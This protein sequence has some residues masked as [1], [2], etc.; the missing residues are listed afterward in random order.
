MVSFRRARR[1]RA[2]SLFAV[3]ALLAVALGI[4]S[5]ATAS[6]CPG[7]QLTQ[8]DNVSSVVEQGGQGETFCL[9]AGVYHIS[10]PLKLRTG[11]T[12][13]GD[14]GAVIDGSRQVGGWSQSGSV[15]V[16]ANQIAKPLYSMAGWGDKGMMYPQSAYGDDLFYDGGALWKAGLK[17]GGKVLGEPASSVGPGEYFIDYDAATI[18]LGSNPAGHLVELAVAEDGVVGGGDRVTVR[19]LEIRKMAGTGIRSGGVGWTIAGN[20]VHHNHVVGI[21][22]NDGARVVTNSVHHNGQYGITGRGDGVL[23]EDNDVAFNDLAKFYGANGNCSAAGGSKFVNTTNLVVRNN[24]FHDNLCNGI[25][26]DILTAGALVEGNVSERNVADGFRTEISYNVTFRNNVAADNGRGGIIINNTPGATV[27]GNTVMGNAGAAISLG[28]SGRTD[29]VSPLGPHETRNADVHDN[30]VVLRRGDVTGM[31]SSVR[32]DCYAG[33]NNRFYRNQYV[34]P[35]LSERMF[36]WNGS[37]LTWSQWQAAGNDA[38]DGAAA[39]TA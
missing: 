14:P 3:G 39:R 15:W 8:G 10:S 35:S 34:L 29:P 23:V 33:W 20:D 16:S 31:R 32:G 5:H 7:T 27:V 37:K 4:G 19:G 9:A 11:Q 2:M 22:G 13:V 38:G 28:Y 1:W 18:T 12:L 17:I 25:W 36:L 30:T 26:L 6:G 24:R 21:V